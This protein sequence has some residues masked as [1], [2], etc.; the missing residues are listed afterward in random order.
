MGTERAFQTRLNRVP[1]DH[2]TRLVFADWL[3]EQGDERGPGYR[4]LG[5]NRF[6]VFDWPDHTEGSLRLWT[7]YPHSRLSY[8]HERE[9]PDDWFT[10]LPAWECL[11]S[12]GAPGGNEGMAWRDYRSRQLADDAAALAFAKL[13]AER[14]AE[15]LS[16]VEVPA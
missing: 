2:H 9:L 12:N 6:W 1:H 5:V 13:P 7:W 4:A 14:R 11:Y 16:P 8:L 3:D 10:R 15:L